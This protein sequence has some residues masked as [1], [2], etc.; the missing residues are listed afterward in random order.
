[1]NLGLKMDEE[2]VKRLLEVA[3]VF[4][5]LQK[6]T[7]GCR[8]EETVNLQ[9]KD[10]FKSNSMRIW[11]TPDPYRKKPSI[12]VVVELSWVRIVVQP[13]TERSSG[14]EVLAC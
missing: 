8:R 11:S 5:L 4:S 7:A 2:H 6:A 3:V 13:V 14:N 12:F 10:A 9:N 1:M